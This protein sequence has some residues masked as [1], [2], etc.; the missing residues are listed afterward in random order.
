MG[1]DR[2]FVTFRQEVATGGAAAAVAVGPGGEYSQQYHEQYENKQEHEQEQRQEQRQRVL[3]RPVPSAAPSAK[4]VAVPQS[5]AVVHVYYSG[6]GGGAGGSN[7]SFPG[8]SVSPSSAVAGGGG[9]AGGAEGFGSI[10][11]GYFSVPSA[12]GGVVVVQASVVAVIDGLVSSNG[13]WAVVSVAALS[14]SVCSI[15]L[16]I[17]CVLICLYSIPIFYSCMLSTYLSLFISLSN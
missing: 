12:G 11:E 1:G 10:G 2:Y 13:A 5:Y 8:V 7:T 14:V 3:A 15:C 9:G 6:S 4:P 16:W 17:L